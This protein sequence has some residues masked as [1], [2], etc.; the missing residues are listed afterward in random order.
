MGRT[1]T[2]RKGK[3]GHTHRKCLKSL[4]ISDRSCAVVLDHIYQH[5]AAQWASLMLFEF[6]LALMKR[7]KTVVA[8]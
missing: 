4:Y 2:C 6:S 7:L 5:L 1:P 3:G 8:A